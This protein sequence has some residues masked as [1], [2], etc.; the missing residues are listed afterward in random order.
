[1]KE[2]KIAKGWSIFIY[3]L[4]P[5]LF[6]LFGWALTQIF[7]AGDFTPHW[8][9]IYFPLSIFM[10]II[11]L[12]GVIDTYKSRLIIEEDKIISKSALSNRELRFEEI[13]GYRFND[14]YI[15]IEPFDREQ[16]KIKISQYV[17]GYK[18]ILNWVS[19]TFPDLDEQTAKEEE[20]GILGDE[21]LGHTKESRAEKLLKARHRARVLNIAGGAVGAWVFFYPSPYQI[22][23][24]VAII[25]PIIVLLVS[26]FSDGL[27]RMKEIK[28][29]AYPHVVF[30]FIFPAMAMVL[31]ALLDYNILDFSRVWPLT[32]LLTI[33]LSLVLSYKQ[34]EFS[35]RKNE[36]IFYLI[37][38]M[39]FFFA[40]S[41]GAVIHVNCYYDD[42]QPEHYTTTVLDKKISTGKTTTYQLKL[43]PWQKQAEAEEIDVSKDLYDRTE[44][45]DEIGID[46]RKGK[47]HIPWIM[48]T[49]E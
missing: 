31:R 37:F 28:K 32:I 43:A 5:L 30:A 24:L 39:L 1:M 48:V 35:F 20:E 36:D 42:S 29:S 18:E 46:I 19:Q 7:P 14:Q 4:A 8:R 44:T 27:I 10:M 26:K 38:L 40:Y 21:N 13:K 11:I 17:G 47:L 9:W 6:V 2:Y 12:I 3:I 25:L 16:K 15:F 41:Y 22:S 49:D 33:V 45:S 34:T 23:L